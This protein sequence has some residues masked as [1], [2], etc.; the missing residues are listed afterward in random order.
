MI[1]HVFVYLHVCFSDLVTSEW[2]GT[3]V[4]ETTGCYGCELVY[5][6]SSYVNENHPSCQSSIEFQE[7]PNEVSISSISCYLELQVVHQVTQNLSSTFG[8]FWNLLCLSTPRAVSRSAWETKE[9]FRVEWILWW[10]LHLPLLCFLEKTWK[11]LHFSPRDQ[12]MFQQLLIFHPL[13][14]LWLT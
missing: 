3:T 10:Q 6:W 14:L 2:S 11:F 5:R 4:L 7:I 8:H 1:L 9:Q 12:R 13:I